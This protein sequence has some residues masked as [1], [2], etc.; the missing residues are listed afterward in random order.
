MSDFLNY[1][2]NKPGVLCG[3]GRYSSG[4]PRFIESTDIV[5]ALSRLGNK[6]NADWLLHS[7]FDYNW[8]WLDKYIENSSNRIDEYYKQFK[9]TLK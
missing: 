6:I 7:I 8:K 2:R 1:G 3:L 4:L 9:E 5:Y